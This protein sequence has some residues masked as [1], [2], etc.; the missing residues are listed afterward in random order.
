MNRAPFQRVEMNRPYRS[1][2]NLDNIKIMDADMGILYPVFCRK[3]VP[4]DHF[5]IRVECVVRANPMVAPIMHEVNIFFH[6]FFVPL[7]IMWPKPIVEGSSWPPDV[8]SWEEFFTGG[9]NGD[10][11]PTKPKWIPTPVG[12]QPGSLWDYLGFPVDVDPVGAYPDSWP[13]RAYNFIYNEYYRDQNYMDEQD[14][15]R[16]AL[17]RRCW[18]KDYF[19]TA[20]PWQQRGQA[21]ALP[22]TGL[23]HAEFLGTVGINADALTGFRNLMFVPNLNPNRMELVGSGVNQDEANKFKAWINNNQ[24]DLSNAST[25]DVS[26]LRLA[27]Q[28]QKFL[29][30]NA[31]AGGRYI[32]QLRAHYGVHPRDDRLQR[33]EYVGGMRTPV[34]VSEVLQTSGTDSNSPQGT[35]A[36]HG[37]SVDRQ[38]IGSYRAQEFGIMMG[39]MSIMPKAVYQQGIDREWLGE[40]RFD[41]LLPEFVSLSEQP[42]FNSELFVTDNEVENQ[43][44]F[45]FQGRFDEYRVSRNYVVGKMRSGVPGSLAFWHLARH[46]ESRPGLNAE[47]LEC[48]P[49][50]DFLAVPS[51][52]AFVVTIGN[53]VRAVRPLPVYGTPG[54]IDHH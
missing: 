37:M 13:K 49:R 27:F 50:K 29:E 24:V 40:T 45:G 32:E 20:L 10:L 22:I 33:P 48:N 44:V 6:Y 8:G 18:Q 52:P 28:T 43:G 46:F 4:G 41:E 36:G 51:E 47:F 5:K 14:L 3:M 7:R 35:L 31:R 23:T 16:G 17:W 11:T 42:V 30:R 2:F 12:R 1:V 21:P 54:L 53:K 25:F 34:I 26:D 15:D 39:I 9:K 19:T 38:R